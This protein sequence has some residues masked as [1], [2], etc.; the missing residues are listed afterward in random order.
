MWATITWRV[1]LVNIWGVCVETGSEQSTHA[2]FSVQPKQCE[3]FAQLSF[4]LFQD[5]S[6][7]V[8]MTWLCTLSYMALSDLWFGCRCFYVVWWHREDTDSVWVV[9]SVNLMPGFQGIAVIIWAFFQLCPFMCC[10]CLYVIN[11]N[12]YRLGIIVDVARLAQALCIIVGIKMP[13]VPLVYCVQ[14]C[15]RYKNQ[16]LFW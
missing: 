8:L 14:G 12:M 11:H 15:I 1:W 10:E 9:S 13:F 3:W 6:G 5:G 7:S 16:H 4:L 2:V